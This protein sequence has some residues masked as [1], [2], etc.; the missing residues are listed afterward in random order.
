MVHLLERPCSPS[1][2]T[3]TC[4]RSMHGETKWALLIESQSQCHWLQCTNEFFRAMIEQGG[5]YSLEKP[6]DFSTLMDIQVSQSVS[7][8]QKSKC[9][10]H[11]CNE[12]SR[13]REERHST[14]TEASLCHLQ[15][16]DT[17]RRRYWPH[18]WH[19]S[20]RT[21]Q[22]EQRLPKRGWPWS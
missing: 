13:R 12:P 8:V 15:L 10:V 22:C 9:S 21:L 7:S 1:S 5:F 3:S 17:H 4:Q 14:S 6:G 20:Q 2:T 11:G 16:H 18:L 19:N